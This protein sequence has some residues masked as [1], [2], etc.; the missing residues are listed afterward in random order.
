MTRSR[1]PA[2][3]QF[4]RAKRS[5]DRDRA[6]SL[7]SMDSRI[8]ATSSEVRRPW[9]TIDLT[10]ARVFFTRWFSSS[11]II[12]ERASSALCRDRSMNEAKC[13]TTSPEAFRTG[14]MKMAHQKGV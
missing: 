9:E 5:W 3:R 1:R 6:N 13:C 11:I 2:L 8:S 4:S 7:D 12:L 14:V 10:V